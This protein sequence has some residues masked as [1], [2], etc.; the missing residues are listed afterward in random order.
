MKELRRR[1][2]DLFEQHFSEQ[3]ICGDN[4]LAVGFFISGET[5][6]V[7]VA[8]S[9]RYSNTEFAGNIWK[10]IVTQESGHPVAHLVC[11]SK[12]GTNKKHTRP[13]SRAIIAWAERNHGIHV[14]V[15]ELISN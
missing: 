15:S 8:L 9:L 14:D 13:S 4:N 1:A 12:P 2:T 3:K 11:L 6:I 5:T 7:Q 10:A